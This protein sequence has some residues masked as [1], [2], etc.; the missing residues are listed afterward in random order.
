ME[1]GP[2]GTGRTLSRIQYKCPAIILPIP[3]ITFT[4]KLHVENAQSRK[5]RGSTLHFSL[6]FRDSLL[7]QVRLICAIQAKARSA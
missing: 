5:I 1:L 3:I 2:S 7:S 4:P 6:H